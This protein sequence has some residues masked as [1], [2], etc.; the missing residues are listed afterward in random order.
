ML[1]VRLHL[2]DHNLQF[3][4]VKKHTT[5]VSGDCLDCHRMPRYAL[6]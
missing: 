3:G 4:W 1:A 5:D 6:I 2:T